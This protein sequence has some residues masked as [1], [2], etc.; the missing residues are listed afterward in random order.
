MAWVVRL[1]LAIVLLG[2][3]AFCAVFVAALEQA[4]ARIEAAQAELAVPPPGPAARLR[5]EGRMLVVPSWR[6]LEPGQL[7]AYAGPKQSISEEFIPSLTEI[8]LPKPAWLADHRLQ[9]Q[10]ATALQH[11]AATAQQAGRPFIVTSAYRSALSQR[12]LEQ[13]LIAAHGPQYAQRFAARPGHSE[14]QLGLAVDLS[15]FTPACQK[16]FAH[17]WLDEATAAWL[18]VTA[19]DHGFILRYPPGKQH[20]T[21]VAPESWHF[22]YVGREM[23]HFIRDSGLTFDEVIWHLQAERQRLAQ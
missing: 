20:I 13:A 19:P 22:R 21:G 7:W 3:A 11:W 16:A 5:V 12:Q 10:A 4:G 8:A 2:Y 17:C 18:A 9:P 15:R 14:H 6:R 1:A 23:A